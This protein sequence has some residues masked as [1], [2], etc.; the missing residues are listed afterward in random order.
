MVGNRPGGELSGYETSHVGFQ[1][2]ILLLIYPTN[3]TLL[4]LFFSKGVGHK[5]T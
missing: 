3:M 2:V 1:K 5:I 4:L